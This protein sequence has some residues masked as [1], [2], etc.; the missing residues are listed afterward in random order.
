MAALLAGGM[1]SCEE[2]NEP[3]SVELNLIDPSK[4]DPAAWEKYTKALRDYKATDHS[5][6]YARLDNA[7]EVSTSEKDFMRALP[8]SLDMVALRRAS[9]L[10]AHD[11]EDMAVMKQKG[12]R[13]LYYIE[14][15][16]PFDKLTAILDK[17]VA[18]V[19][20]HGFD[21]Y[22]VSVNM[23]FSADPATQAAAASQIVAKLSATTGKML[24]FEGNPTFIAEADRAKFNYFVLD[25]TAAAHVMEVDMAID[26]A[27]G[28]ASVPASKIILSATPSATITAVDNTKK[29]ALT[30]VSRMVFTA[31][32][33]AGMGVYNVGEDYYDASINY[34]RT[35]QVIQLLNPAHKP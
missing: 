28:Y 22:V 19:A 35:K 9:A 15:A 29:D 17:A 20:A 10:T 3:E 13:V 27:T 31:G 18:D 25:T 23:D 34:R 6:V 32:P 16:S 4:Q 2:W 21:G 5:L 12:T 11:M 1:T 33:L 8:D 7:P 24:V 30:E 14:V 26:Y